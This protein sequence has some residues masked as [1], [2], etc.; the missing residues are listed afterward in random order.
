MEVK[1]NGVTAKTN[2]SSGRY[3]SRFHWPGG[4]I[5][6]S[7]RIRSMKCGFQR[8]KSMI[9]QAASISAWYGV[10]DWPSMVAA[11]SVWRHGPA[12]RSAA[13][14]KIAARSAGAIAAQ[15]L[16]AAVAAS[17]AAWTSARP[18]L[19]PAG[20]PLRVA[21]RNARLGDPAGADLAA[22]DDERDLELA[23]ARARRAAPSARSRSGV[24]GP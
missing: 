18:G 21:V 11:F 23:A 2:P 3:S 19:V 8:Q 13:L 15:V 17:I 9:S 6:W 7:A 22:A 1:L 14:R 20:E 10:F 5:G 16:R 12:R 24:P 4:E